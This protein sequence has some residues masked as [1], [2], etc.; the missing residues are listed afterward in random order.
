MG[1]VRG[2]DVSAAGAAFRSGCWERQRTR[3]ASG[4]LPLAIGVR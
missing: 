4:S 3:L 1:D 2:P